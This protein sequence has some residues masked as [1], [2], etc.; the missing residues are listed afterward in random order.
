MHEDYVTV[1]QDGDTYFVAEMWFDKRS[2]DHFLYDR[3]E[4]RYGTKAEA[5]EVALDWADIEGLAYRD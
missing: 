5:L 3:G 1:I 4:L 2:G